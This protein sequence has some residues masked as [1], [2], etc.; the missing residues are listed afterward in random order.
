MK[1]TV[2]MLP[3]NF[4]RTFS[5]TVILVFATCLCQCA[6]RDTARDNGVKI[7][8]VKNALELTTALTGDFVTQ[9]GIINSRILL[10]PGTYTLSPTPMVESICGNCE[11]PATPVNVTVGLQVG[12]K[13]VHIVG[14][15]DGTAEIVTTAG[16]GIFFNECEACS[17]SGVSPRLSRS[18]YSLAACPNSDSTE[19]SSTLAF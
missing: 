15:S 11:D 9:G 12:G 18:E 10:A 17:I 3:E 2:S 19:G 14:P 7:L 6:P 4:S 1:Q 8:H 13:N 16:Y 5:A